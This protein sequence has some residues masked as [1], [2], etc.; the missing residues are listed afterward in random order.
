MSRG[1]IHLVLNVYYRCSAHSSVPPEIVA[2]I[3]ATLRE[4]Q[5]QAEGKDERRAHTIR[6]SPHR[7]P[8]SHGR[9]IH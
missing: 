8:H 2:Q 6:V 7:D 5:K 3:V 4:D 1:N 9:R